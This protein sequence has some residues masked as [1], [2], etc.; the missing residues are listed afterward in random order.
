MG[1]MSTHRTDSLKRKRKQ[2]GARKKKRRRARR[3]FPVWPD[4]IIIVCGV[5]GSK[6]FSFFPFFLFF[7]FFFFFLAC[8]QDTGV[9]LLTR[10]AKKPSVRLRFSFYVDRLLIIIWLIIIV[11]I[12]IHTLPSDVLKQIKHPHTPPSSPCS[13]SQLLRRERPP[14]WSWWQQW[15]TLQMCA[16]GWYAGAFSVVG[17]HTHN[18]VSLSVFLSFFLLIPS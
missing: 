13:H 15:E 17:V 7:F 11:I 3:K 16:C 10:K 12:N 4:E 2:R 1:M 14:S 6:I 5:F 8:F 18:S 9:S